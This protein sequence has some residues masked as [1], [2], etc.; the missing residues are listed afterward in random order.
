MEVA[1]EVEDDV[2]FADLNK[3]ISLLIKDD[4]D[5]PAVTHCPPVSL[6]AFPRAMHTAG[7]QSSFSYQEVFKRESKGTGVFIPQSSSPHVGRK[8]R[9][10]RSFS[11][12]NT[13]LQRHH[14]DNS[15]GLQRINPSHNSIKP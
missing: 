15:R 14:P 12:A 3:Q 2:F 7:A 4:E 8:H 5:G 11:S 6:Q 1:M 9:H 13:K 10:G